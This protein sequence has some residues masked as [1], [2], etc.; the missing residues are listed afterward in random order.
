MNIINRNESR[1]KP[2]EH[3]NFLRGNPVT[4]E[5]TTETS[6]SSKIYFARCNPGWGNNPLQF[7]L[8]EHRLHLYNLTSRHQPEGAP[9]P[10]SLLC[11]P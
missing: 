6:L 7:T 9:T 1:I 5:K 10:A 4:G 3:K 11:R 8:G 2:Y